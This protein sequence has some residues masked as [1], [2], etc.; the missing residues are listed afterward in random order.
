METSAKDT[1][2]IDELFVSTTKTFMEKQSSFAPGKG[3]KTPGSGA[4]NLHSD[5]TVKENNST[6][7]GGCC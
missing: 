1:V 2:N 5:A 3:K 7:A 6:N 4:V